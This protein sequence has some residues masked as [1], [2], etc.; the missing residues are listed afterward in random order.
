MSPLKEAI[1]DAKELRTLGL[2]YT[3]G[4]VSGVCGY[5]VTGSIIRLSGSCHNCDKR[6]SPTEIEEHKKICSIP[7]EG[8]FNWRLNESV[9]RLKKYD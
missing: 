4:Q 9:N 8:S 3:D 7:L 6:L 1:A 2:S 5:D